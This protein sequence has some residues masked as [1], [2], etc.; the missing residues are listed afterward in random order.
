VDAG[1]TACEYFAIFQA[2][3]TIRGC[4]EVV[5]PAAGKTFSEQIPC[6]LS[7]KAREHFLPL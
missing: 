1:G 7:K 6:P 3:E 4:L 2:S 5:S